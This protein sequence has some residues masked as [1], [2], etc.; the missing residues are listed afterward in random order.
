MFD[1]YKGGRLD[2]VEEAAIN[3]HHTAAFRS[4]RAEIRPSEINPTLYRDWLEKYK[5]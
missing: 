1:T 5:G 4:D 3:A 2:D